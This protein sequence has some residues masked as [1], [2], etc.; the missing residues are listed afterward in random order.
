MPSLRVLD[1]GIY[2]YMFHNN[3]TG[4]AFLW[5]SDKR[6]DIDALNKSKDY[7]E[8]GQSGKLFVGPT[9]HD[10]MRFVDKVTRRALNE[11]SAAEG[12]QKD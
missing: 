8:P 12:T 6:V 11:E 5:Q 3:D 4:R 7:L 10:E 9:G 2:F 1:V